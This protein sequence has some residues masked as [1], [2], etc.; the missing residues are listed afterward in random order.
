[1]LILSFMAFIKAWSYTPNVVQPVQ[2]EVIWAIISMLD[3][4]LFLKAQ[5]ALV[6]PALCSCWTCGFQVLPSC[7]LLQFSS[8]AQSC[9][10]LCDPMDCSTP[11][12]PVHHQLLEFTQTHVHWD[13][14]AINHFSSK[15]L[16]NPVVVN[17]LRST[18]T[19][20]G[21]AQDHHSEVWMK[22]HSWERQS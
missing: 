1:M 17:G 16:P 11:G 18:V 21:Q 19:N 14:D 6:D 4:I 2:I 5:G 13:D 22:E 9:P 8:V 20:E 10:T 7:P 15:V 3:M 12:L